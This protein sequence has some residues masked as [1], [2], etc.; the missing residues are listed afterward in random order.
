M[1]V[2]GFQV[3]PLGQQCMSIAGLATTRRRCSQIT[4]KG[5]Y[6]SQALSNLLIML[7]HKALLLA[8]CFFGLAGRM[9]LA[10]TYIS[11]VISS[12]T[13]WT[14]AAS[15]YI[16]TGN[17]VLWQGSTLTIEPGVLVQ[18]GANVAIDIRGHLVASGTPTDSIFFAPSGSATWSGFL[19]SNSFGATVRFNY[20]SAVHSY[21]LFTPQ[22]NTAVADTILH[23]YPYRFN[24]LRS[25]R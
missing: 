1:Q 5:A 7:N 12:S 18:V 20:V 15:P 11:G 8:A 17:T 16:V 10:Q 22:S 24:I 4:G 21:R 23:L 13:T 14:A 6:L 25:V 9:C 19:I 3:G 2:E